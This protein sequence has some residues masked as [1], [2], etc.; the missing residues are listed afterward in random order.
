MNDTAF[1]FPCEFALK[2]MGRDTP[3]F[4]D[5]ALAIGYG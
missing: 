3:G 2:V 4:H 5:N 1:E